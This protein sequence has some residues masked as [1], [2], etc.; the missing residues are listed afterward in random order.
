MNRLNV[1]ADR[2]IKGF[3]MERTKNSRRIEF[4]QKL[5]ILN[6]NLTKSKHRRTFV[7][8]VVELH[9]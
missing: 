3:F 2:E 7:I 1:K 9:G 6:K 4:L 5:T 8:N